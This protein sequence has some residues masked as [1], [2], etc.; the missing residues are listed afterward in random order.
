MQV[1]PSRFAIVS[2]VIATFAAYMDGAAAQTPVK[3]SIDWAFQGHH[4]PFAVALQKK[5]F[6]RGALAVA[7]DRG[8][9]S[10]CTISKVANGNGLPPASG[11]G[12]GRLSVAQQSHGNEGCRRGRNHSDRRRNCQYNCIRAVQL[13]RVSEYIAALSSEYLASN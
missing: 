4:A 11:Y 9:G 12:I 8:R 5:Y 10:G 6:E 3:F 7:M 1:R 13:W 2:L